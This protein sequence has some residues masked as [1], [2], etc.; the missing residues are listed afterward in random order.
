MCPKAPAPVRKVQRGVFSTFLFPRSGI[1]TRGN[2]EPFKPAHSPQHSPGAV[3]SRMC[4][5]MQG[6]GDR[7]H[8]ESSLVELVVLGQTLGACPASLGATARVRGPS[9]GATLLVVCPGQKLKSKISSCPSALIPL[10]W[11]IQPYA[12]AVECGCLCFCLS[13][14]CE[15]LRAPSVGA[16]LGIGGG[17][18]QG[19]HMRLGWPAIC[20]EPGISPPWVCK[21]RTMLSIPFQSG[22]APRGAA[23]LLCL[24]LHRRRVLS[25]LMGRELHPVSS[26][27]VLIRNRLP[28]LRARLLQ[29]CM[30]TRP[31]VFKPS[32]LFT[33]FKNLLPFPNEP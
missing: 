7:A 9:P 19:L 3:G 18:R 22:Q 12:E 4:D 25:G 31:V 27:S 6:G 29:P 28:G 5:A 13:G 2:K 15:A 30:E 24:R 16:G 26:F 23:Q 8:P 14:A 21:T 1:I 11:L 32:C 20:W 10:L 33:L 17:Q